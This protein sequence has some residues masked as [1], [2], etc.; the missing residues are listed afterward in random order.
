MTNNY[1]DSDY[2]SLKGSL[3][4]GNGTNPVVHTV[5]SNGQLLISDSAQTDGLSWING[6]LNCTFTA[7]RTSN[8]SNVTG[9]GTNYT[10]VYDS[11]PVNIT[12]SYNTST[13]IFTAPYAGY[14]MFTAGVAV[15]GAG[16]AH[17]TGTTVFLHNGS[18]AGARWIANYYVMMN[19]DGS[20]SMGTVYEL[21]Q[22]DTFAVRFMVSGGTK[23]VGI[24]G[25]GNGVTT[26]SGFL[27]HA[28]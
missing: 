28:D 7:V 2:N 8:L 4:A 10:V 22:S 11:A 17:T 13:G 23:T 12:S 24:R 16:P 14:Y 25:A 5:G 3:L 9:N 20:A 26:F 6:P 15:S 19:S 27:I 1:W 18:E 21:A